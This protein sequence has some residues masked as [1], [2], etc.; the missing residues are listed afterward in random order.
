MEPSCSQLP[1][2]CYPSLGKLFNHIHVHVEW[3]EM[4]CSVTSRDSLERFV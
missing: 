3:K 2:L 4:D 1:H